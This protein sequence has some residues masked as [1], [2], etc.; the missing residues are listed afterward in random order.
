MIATILLGS[1]IISA[2]IGVI[3]L[4]HDDEIV[5]WFIALLIFCGFFL[6][7]SL[8]FGRSITKT[9]MTKSLQEKDQIEYLLENNPSLYVIEEAKSYNSDIEYGNTYWCRFTIED[10][11]TYKIDIDSYIKE[12]ARKD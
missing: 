1:L 4:R 6:A 9:N 7:M 11:D 8:A 5:G 12:W 3:L 10:R 2:I